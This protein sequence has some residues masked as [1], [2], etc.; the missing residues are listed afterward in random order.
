M[1]EYGQPLLLSPP[2][3]TS[4]PPSGTSTMIARP[5]TIVPSWPAARNT[6]P[7]PIIRM[8]TAIMAAKG[9]RMAISA[10]TLCLLDV[11]VIGAVHRLVR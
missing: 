7:R 9:S 8:A 2:R 10:F 4:H 5:I 3:V 6:L 1:I 11:E